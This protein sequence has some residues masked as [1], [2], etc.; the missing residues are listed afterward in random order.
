[1]CV[2]ESIIAMQHKEGAHMNAASG[3]KNP[4]RSLSSSRDR[5]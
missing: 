3:A 2:E 1:M 5:L 4:G